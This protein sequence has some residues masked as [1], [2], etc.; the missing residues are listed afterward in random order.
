M[1]CTAIAAA[2]AVMLTFA[3]NPIENAHAGDSSKKWGDCAYLFEKSPAYRSHGCKI[4]KRECTGLQGN[5]GNCYGYRIHYGSV[6]WCR[7]RARC[8]GIVQPSSNAEAQFV[9]NPTYI[10]AKQNATQRLDNCNGK[11]GF[12]C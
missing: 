10:S 3:L 7:I 11:L 9:M 5:S 8:P 1:Q 6:N 4:D 2:L 12:R